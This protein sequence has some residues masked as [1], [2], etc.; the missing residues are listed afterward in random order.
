MQYT[1]TRTSGLN[2]SYLSQTVT[3][4]PVVLETNPPQNA[5]TKPC[6][7]FV[8][9]SC[10]RGESC[11]FVHTLDTVQRQQNFSRSSIGVPPPPNQSGA[12]N[13]LANSTST[14]PPQSSKLRSNAAA[15]VNAVPFTPSLSGAQP[16]VAAPHVSAGGGVTAA[17]QTAENEIQVEDISTNTNNTAS[18]NNNNLVS[19][20]SSG[21][22]SSAVQ[23]TPN[24][25]KIQAVELEI[26]TM[27][28]T[29][30]QLR[31]CALCLGDSSISANGMPKMTA[32]EANYLEQT[33]FRCLPSLYSAVMHL[34][35]CLVQQQA[36]PFDTTIAQAVR[37]AN[38]RLDSAIDEYKTGALD[39][40]KRGPSVL[41]ATLPSTVNPLLTSPENSVAPLLMMQQQQ[42]LHSDAASQRASVSPPPAGSVNA[43]SNS[44]CPLNNNIMNSSAMTAAMSALFFN[45]FLHSAGTPGGLQ[46]LDP[47]LFLNA[48][49]TSSS[50]AALPHTNPHVETTGGGRVNESPFRKK[51]GGAATSNSNTD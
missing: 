9:G 32:L 19:S 4:S 33:L 27:M 13:N 15:F 17:P 14:T 48:T 20:N 50:A 26:A 37:A 36:F 8:Q 40:S 51:N 18:G 16:S 39:D 35:Q 28:S 24:S 49:T 22:S 41:S 23:K 1:S 7:F 31:D 3:P 12:S 30:A 42:L 21:T 38:H 29:A 11:S 45:P 34:R 46:G 10:S 25:Q 6:R 43:A 47:C 5:F 2:D 44:P